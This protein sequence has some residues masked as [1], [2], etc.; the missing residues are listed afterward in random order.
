LILLSTAGCALVDPT[1]D[2]APDGLVSIGFEVSA[3]EPCDSDEI[4]WMTGSDAVYEELDELY[5]EVVGDDGGPAYA[6]LHGVRS[7]KG[8][9]GH[10]GAYDREFRVTQIID[11]VGPEGSGCRGE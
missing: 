2:A 4:W 1:S 5:Q 9:Y 6:R 11:V 3:F 8:S 10:L 7:T